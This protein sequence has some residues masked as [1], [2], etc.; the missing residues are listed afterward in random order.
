M[1]QRLEEWLN[2]GD[3]ESAEYSRSDCFG[4][5][6]QLRQVQMETI[7]LRKRAHFSGRENIKRAWG[8]HRVF[9]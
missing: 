9:S 5:K 4:N 7:L 8:Y 3:T 6:H 2:N 1:G